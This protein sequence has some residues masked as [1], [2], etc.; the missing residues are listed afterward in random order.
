MPFYRGLSVALPTGRVRHLLQCF[1]PDIVHLAAPAVLGAAGAKAARSLGIPSV[2]VYQT[3]F[4]G[5]ARRYGLGVASPAMWNWLRWVHSQTDLT[6]APSSLACW[7]LTRHRI[8]PVVKWGRGVDLQKFHPRH[9]SPLLRRRLA[10]NGETVVGYVG[11][12]AP[13]KRVHLLH[14]VLQMPGVRVVVVGDGP[15]ERAL[16]RRLPSAQ[17]LGFQ[18]GAELSQTLAS[19]DVF[20]HTGADETF[21]QTIQEALASGV[22]V[23]DTCRGWAHGPG[24]PRRQRMAVPRRRPCA[25]AKRRR[26]A[27]R[28][29]HPAS[30]HGSASPRLGRAPELGRAGRRAR[31]PLPQALGGGRGFA[32]G[33]PD[34]DPVVDRR[35]A[36]RRRARD[37]AGVRAVDRRPSKSSACRP[38]CWS[39][40]GRG[41]CRRSATIAVSAAGCAGCQGRGHEIAQHGWTHAATRQGSRGRRLIGRAVA[42]GCAEFWTLDEDEAARRLALGRAQLRSEGIDSVGFVPPGWLASAGALRSMRALGYRYTTSHTAVIDFATGARHRPLPCRTGREAPSSVPARP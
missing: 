6:L 23:G 40:R 14:H 29:R 35:L 41:R 42:R 2:A 18:T 31:R 19:L 1:S 10:P 20:V 33:W 39:C 21:C 4:A 30:G 37:Q 15:S 11:R 34:G 24:T 25:A 17:F 28:R 27:R 8:G 32:A 36:P 16:R 7:D 3:D 22:P 5:F 12:L 13:E 9:R 26:R 38:R